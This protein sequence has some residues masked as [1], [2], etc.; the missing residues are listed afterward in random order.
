ML[1]VHS[2]YRIEDCVRVQ[3]SSI[4]YILIDLNIASF[5]LFPFAFIR[6]F[7]VFGRT[8]P[9]DYIGCRRERTNCSSLCGNNKRQWA[10]LQYAGADGCESQSNRQGIFFFHFLFPGPWMKLK[11]K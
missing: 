4:N 11:D 2:V 1:N 8:I 3:G 9:R 10:L 5:R 6:N 7:T